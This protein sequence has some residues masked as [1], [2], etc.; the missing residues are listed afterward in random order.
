MSVYTMY[1]DNLIKSV[2]LRQLIPENQVTFTD[3]DL[4]NFADEEMAMGIVPM[5]IRMH[6]DYL[7][8]TE[9]VAVTQNTNRYPIPYRA[10]GNKLREVSYQDSSGNIFEMTRIGVGDLAY[11]NYQ[12]YNRPYAFYIENN[13]IVLVPGNNYYSAG[14]YLKVSYY[15]R[16]NALVLLKDVAPV[17]S[18][19]RNTGEIQ[20]SN[21]PST[22]NTNQLFDF[23][24]IK[25][26]N[27]TLKYDLAVS[28]INT[29]SKIITLNPNDIPSGLVVGDHLCLATQ[30]AIVQIPS[31][32]HVILAQRV[33]LRCVEALG[34]IEALSAGNQKLAELEQ[35]A[36]ALI[37]NR[38]ED[39]PR[40]IVN[41][42]SSLSSSMMRRRSRFRGF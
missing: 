35:K 31:D 27:K 16:P 15:L 39:A 42:H 6:E 20:V 11:Y 28:G 8:Y 30:T 32:L 33:G 1:S 5:I 3:T 37:D 38:V 9:K 26:P 40:K 7:L 22:Y 10:V 29:A 13:E 14:T 2:K 19:D 23:V 34:D 41:K 4:L 25:S 36:E 18:I 24:S 21:L 17:T 12:T